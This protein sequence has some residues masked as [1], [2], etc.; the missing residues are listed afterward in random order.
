MSEFS[1]D[2]DI[3]RII[4]LIK[5]SATNQDPGYIYRY[6][7][8]LQKIA[9]RKYKSYIDKQKTKNVNEQVQDEVLKKV[10]EQEQEEEEEGEEE[11][12]EVQEEVQEQEE[13]EVRNNFNPFPCITSYYPTNEYILAYE[14]IIQLIINNTS[15]EAEAQKYINNLKKITINCNTYID[16]TYE[17]LKYKKFFN[18]KPIKPDM[19]ML[20]TDLKRTLGIKPEE[21][22]EE[23]DQV[24][25]K[26]K[27]K[28]NSK[29][30]SKKPVVSQKKQSIYKEIF[31]KKMKIYKM[32]D[33]RKEYVKYK[34]ELHHIADYKNLMKQKAIAK[35]KTKVT[36]VTQQ[37]AIA[38]TKTTKV[39]KVTQHKAIAKTKA[40]K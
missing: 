8:Y 29:K 3:K 34:G 38:K 10:Q 35:T 28:A 25:G 20:N 15:N 9:M 6:L 30:V 12:E 36:K 17:V 11:Q 1:Q 4:T 7:T 21:A 37:K 18:K 14:N 33:S 24:G 39:T 31:G 5:S 40:K 22:V 2:N 13:E 27:S 26:R 19:Q 23:A 16:T 32:P